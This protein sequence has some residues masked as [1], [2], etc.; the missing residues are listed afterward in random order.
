MLAC[1]QGT[2]RPTAAAVQPHQQAR[3]EALL[4]MQ[5]HSLG[6]S[7]AGAKQ[8]ADPGR[9]AVYLNKLESVA[10]TAVRAADKVPCRLCLQRWLC[11]LGRLASAAPACRSTP[12]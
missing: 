4:G 12:A 11:S 10:S 1:G 7:L 6:S 8:I 5:L 9:R 2:G 3:A